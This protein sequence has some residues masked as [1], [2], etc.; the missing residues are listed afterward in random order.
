MPHSASKQPEFVIKAKEK[1]KKQRRSWLIKEIRQTASA[2]AKLLKK[3]DVQRRKY[4]RAQE[5]F[6]KHTGTEQQSFHEKMID[7]EEYE[8]ELRIEVFRATRNRV[9][10]AEAVRIFNVEN[11]SMKIIL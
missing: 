10:A 1:K 2:Q 4:V 6:N 7:A 9:F 8:H 3:A 11:P 5:L